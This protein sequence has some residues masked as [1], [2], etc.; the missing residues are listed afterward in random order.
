MMVAFVICTSL[1]GFYSLPSVYKHIYPRPHNSSMGIL[2]FNATCILSMSSAVPLQASFLG[3]ATPSFPPV[4]YSTLNGEFC[5]PANYPC[6]QLPLQPLLSP[7]STHYLDVFQSD[8][9]SPKESSK[10][11]HYYNLQL[12]HHEQDPS[13]VNALWM[14]WRHPI[15]YQ[16]HQRTTPLSS[17]PPT[18]GLMIV[19][20]YN[21]GFIAIC[22]RLFRLH[23]RDLV[24]V[25]EHVVSAWVWWLGAAPSNSTPR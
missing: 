21:L 2:L 15:Q 14:K 6:P 9:F 5:R 24:K 4:Y 23:V 1:I 19:L 7:Y 25:K 3:L 20:V 10:P 12:Q 22:W 8:A 16:H 17:T 11:L 13:R 18:R